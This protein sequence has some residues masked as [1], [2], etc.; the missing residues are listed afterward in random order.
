MNYDNIADQYDEWGMEATTDWELGH[1]NVAKLLKL[2]KGKK[3][4]DFGCGNGKFSTYL[5][6]RGAEVVGVDISA[7]QLEVAKKKF[8]EDIVFFQDTDPNWR[9]TL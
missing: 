5:N 3:I 2:E 7:A 8:G 6:E 9:V 4:L 1:K